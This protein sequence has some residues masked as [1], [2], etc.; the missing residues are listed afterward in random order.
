MY[1]SSRPSLFQRPTVVTPLMHLKGSSAK[2]GAGNFYG[3]GRFAWVAD[4]QRVEV[5]S[6]ESGQ[7]V[8]GWSRPNASII[9]VAEMCIS[10]RRSLLLFGLLSDGKHVL[11]VFDPNI[12]MVTRALAIPAPIVIVRAVSPTN[13]EMPGLFSSTFLEHFSGVVA[14]GCRGGHVYLVDLRLSS[15]SSIRESVSHPH[16]IYVVGWQQ[17]CDGPW[18]ACGVHG[19]VQLTGNSWRAW[20]GRGEGFFCI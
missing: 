3:N 6:V 11:A 15:G 5:F 19:S 10:P 7:R 17:A 4:S 14:V 16:P 20:G 12:S 13:P 18:R 8:S 9:C 2:G 1:N